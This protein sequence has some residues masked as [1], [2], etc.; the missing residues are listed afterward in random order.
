MFSYENELIINTHNNFNDSLDTNSLLK[1]EKSE[2]N[3]LFNDKIFDPSNIHNLQDSF[4]SDSNS[5]LNMNEVLLIN[6]GE[7]IGKITLEQKSKNIF[8]I[9][10]TSTNRTTDLNPRTKK[11]ILP[12]H[13]T[14]EKI[15]NEIISK[16]NLDETA[17]SFYI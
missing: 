4:S 11:I 6:G 7:N 15:K 17:K 10:I 16:L 1:D 2:L 8:A 9:E 12:K 5:S 3:F 13:Y 14:F